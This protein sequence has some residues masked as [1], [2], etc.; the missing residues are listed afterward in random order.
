MFDFTGTKNF[1]SIGNSDSTLQKAGNGSGPNP[2]SG[3][4]GN[5]DGALPLPPGKSAPP[6]P[7]PPPPPPP[8]APCPPPPPKLVRPPPNPPKS[9]NKLRP[10]PLGPH[11]QGKNDEADVSGDSNTPKPKLKPFSWEKVPANPDHSMVWHDIK[12]GSF[13]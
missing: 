7:G 13:Q 3:A 10:S 9:G 11:R 12:A 2:P 1:Q 5:I 6:P 8:P 4:S